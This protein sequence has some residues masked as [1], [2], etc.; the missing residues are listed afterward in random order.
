MSD[1]YNIETSSLK[2]TIGKF[3][4]LDADSLT[5][6]GQNVSDLVGSGSV[7]VE[8]AQD[9]RRT[10]TENDLWGQWVE[11]L[12]DGTVILHDE[13]LNNQNAPSNIYGIPAKYGEHSW[14]ANITKVQDNVAYVD[15]ELWA[16]VQ[17][18]RIVDGSYM[19]YEN[20]S[21][22]D[23]ELS[24][25]NNGQQMFSSTKLK[26]FK[27]VMPKLV[28]GKDMFGDCNN[29]HTFYSDLSS[30]VDGYYM[31]YNTS[32]SN[33]ISDDGLNNLVNGEYM[34]GMTNLSSFY[35]QLPALTNGRYMFYGC[36][37]FTGFYHDLP[38][39]THG[40][41]M[42]SE[43]TGL[44]Q[45]SNNLSNL[46]DGGTMFYECSALKSF[47][48]ELNNLLYARYMF[49]GCKNLT[50]F[51]SNLKSLIDGM[52]MFYQC[53][54][55]KQF[56][57]NLSSLMD[58][59]SM[60]YSCTNLSSFVS[61]LSSVI[62]AR[63]MFSGCSKLTTFTSDLSSLIM[64][65]GMFA[66]CKLDS[67]S[68]M[69]IANSIN[70]I[71]AEKKLY[72][73]GVKPYVAELS[74]TNVFTSNKGFMSDGRY[75]YMRDM[76]PVISG[77]SNIG[78][79]TIGINVTNN[80]S[81]IQ[82]QLQ[83]FAEEASFGSW[84]EL[85]QMFIDKGW[86]VTWQYGG[87]TTSITYDL[88]GDRAIPCAVYTNLV[89]LLPEGVKLNQQGEQLQEKF[90]TEEQKQ[91][92]THCNDDGTKYYILEWGHEVDR[93]EQ[94]QQFNSL[95]EAAVAYGVMPKEYLQLENQQQLF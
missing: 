64:G 49:G 69:F 89:E 19:F 66:S 92:A 35:Y 39:L 79:I 30:L 45:F 12:D 91:S 76:V 33:F 5:I 10:V 84:A 22:F 81:T 15:D 44:I 95:E 27:V 83:T 90:Y 32:L 1:K 11:K 70:D 40:N 57:T 24:N 80:A 59:T 43:C 25:L 50:L 93:P 34:F 60:F 21:S 48:S 53:Q 41:S 68:V 36:N 85:K 13:F 14:N 7:T 58:G 63:H 55:L 51:D 56:A 78:K 17:T 87:T 72:T 26:Q 73:D 47:T 42:F 2:A 16:N 20:L 29:M 71:V 94:F 61:D 4:K 75:V 37:L 8:H 52:Y 31:F 88:R 38:S 28:N 23:S 18:D 9:T 86:T 74:G 46:I 3:R 65:S 77:A 82:Q 67:A 62:D 6:K 54:N